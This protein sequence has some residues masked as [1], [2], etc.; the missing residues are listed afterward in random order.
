MKNLIITLF[1]ISCLFATAGTNSFDPSNPINI[2]GKTVET[3]TARFTLG[4][5]TLLLDMKA[6]EGEYV[7]ND[8][9]RVINAINSLPEGPEVKLLIAPG[10]YWIDDPDDPSIRDAQ[11]GVPFG[12]TITCDTLSIIGLNPNPENTV[13]ASNRGQTQGAIGNFTMIHYIGKSVE[14]HNITLGNYCNVD[15]VYPLDNSLNR[16][17]RGNAIVQA[18]LGI[19]EGTDRLFSSNCRY[20]SRL[21]LCPMVGARRSLYKDCHFESTDDALTGSAVYLD[22][23]FTFFSSKPF[24]NTPSTGAVF[25]NCDID[26]HNTGVQYLTKVPGPVTLIDTR[27]HSIGNTPPSEMQWTRD[28]S[29]VVCYQYN[30]TLDGKPITMDE[31]RPQLTV[32]L[33][34]KQSLEAFRIIDANGNVLYNTPSLL[35]GAANWDPLSMRDRII[36]ATGSLESVN[37]PVTILFDKNRINL[38]A[39]GDSIKI[40][41]KLVK[42]GNYS[43]DNRLDRLDWSFPSVVTLSDTGVN[44]CQIVK[45]KNTIPNDVNGYIYVT[46][47]SGLKGA[48]STKVDAFLTEPPVFTSA[49]AMFY[50]KKKKLMRLE[51]KLDKED[52]RSHIVWYRYTKADLSDTIPVFHGQASDARQYNLSPADIGYKIFANVV[53]QAYGTYPGNNISATLNMVISPKMAPKAKNHESLTTTFATVPIHNQPLL[54]RGA[55][56]F[57]CYK[58]VE[59]D[60]FDWKADNSRPAWYYGFGTDGA[61]SQGLVQASRGAR[62]FYTPIVETSDSQVVHLFLEPCKPAGQGFGS[63]TGQFLD[64]YIGFDPSTLSGHALRIER[65]PGYDHAVVFSLVEYRNGLVHKISESVPSSCFRTTCEVILTIEKGVLTAKASTNSQPIKSTA[66]D[67]VDS[68][69]ISAPIDKIAGTS[70]GFQHTGT[71]GGGA[72]LIRELDANW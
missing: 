19:C 12:T 65:T 27:F 15:L 18:Q 64:I 28:E 30:V 44:H 6:S 50:D 7:F 71:T 37:R 56:T 17:K 14:L 67:V 69:N 63:A 40:A 46:S 66:P 34:G 21:N 10:V 43:L 33:E 54:V 55:W 31:K 16:T 4:E 22:C 29:S 24:Y 11:S 26:L 47:S 48:I 51:Y 1:S 39:D 2:N 58:P 49:P 8:I 13:F 57:D 23:H 52:D 5:R 3:K 70:I 41:P 61:V 38:A 60:G 45:S 53:P 68:V 9:S 35:G 36:A 32:N 20:I 62:A 59:T 72:T 42:W 25:L